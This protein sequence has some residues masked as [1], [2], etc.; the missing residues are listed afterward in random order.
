MKMIFPEES[1]FAL[2]L[3]DIFFLTLAARSG[4]KARSGAF[5]H[6]DDPVKNQREEGFV[7]SSPATGGTRRAKL[8]REAHL[9]VRGNDE[10]EAQR[11]RWIFY[12]TL[13]FH[14]F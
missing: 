1:P 10:V 3:P 14:P 11:R 6:F 7:K 2:R 13:N 9:R 4:K 12:E 5:V 8:R